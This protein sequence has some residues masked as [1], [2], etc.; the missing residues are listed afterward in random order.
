MRVYHK[1]KR[2]VEGLKHPAYR[3]Y[4]SVNNTQNKACNV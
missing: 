2:F 1:P 4:A 3:V